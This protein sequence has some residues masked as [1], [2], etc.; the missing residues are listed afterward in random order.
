MLEIAQASVFPP[1]YAHRQKWK[2]FRQS[3][4]SSL[5]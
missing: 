3:I 4:Q 1:G 5:S 2:N